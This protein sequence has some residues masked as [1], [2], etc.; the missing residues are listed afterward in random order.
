MPAINYMAVAVAGVVGWLVGAAWYGV[1]GKQ[2]MAALGKDPAD[3]IGPDGKPKPMPMGPMVLS[4]I[5]VLVMA[6][7]LAGVT[8]HI[9][10]RPTIVAGIAAGV[11][12][13][14]GFV[15]TTLSVNNAFAGRKPTLTMIDGLHWLAVL[16]VQGVVLGFFG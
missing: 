9:V 8:G 2:W 6:L 11:L 3:C 7:M 5:A 4:L 1:L 14:L 12:V 15:I 10:P 16:L 13:W